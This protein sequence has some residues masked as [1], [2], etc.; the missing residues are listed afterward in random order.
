M[1][2][3]GSNAIQLRRAIEQRMAKA[4]AMED[5][6]GL[7]NTPEWLSAPAPAGP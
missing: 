6:I 5:G 3:R 7:S 2:F 1:T 4:P